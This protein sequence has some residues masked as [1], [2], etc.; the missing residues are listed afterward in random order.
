MSHPLSQTLLLQSAALCF[1]AAF[2]SASSAAAFFSPGFDRSKT[3][4][5]PCLYQTFAH[6]DASMIPPIG[7]STTRKARLWNCPQND[8]SD[9]TIESERMQLS[10]KKTWSDE[11]Q[12]NAV[13]LDLLP[14]ATSNSKNTPRKNSLVAVIFPFMVIAITVIFLPHLQ[15]L[16]TIIL[17][18][19]L[20]SV[21][22]PLIV[23][24]EFSEDFLTTI[25]PDATAEN[26]QD[27]RLDS[28]ESDNETC[29]DDSIVLLPLQIDATLIVLSYL[30]SSL[31]L[32]PDSNNN[33]LDWLDDNLWPVVAL[34]GVGGAGWVIFQQ[35]VVDP[36]VSE[37]QL[38]YQDKLM[39]TWDRAFRKEQERE[40]GD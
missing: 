20:R 9:D 3:I 2:P 27:F 22:F 25:S 21:A 5:V 31:L 39:N 16:L 8:K 28:D 17:F 7:R 13:V 1:V 32:P 18:V 14:G 38:S 35:S 37:E 30:S 12:K 10:R 33:S 19:A 34:L 40:S 23:C 15:A 6:H 11:D 26:S 36:V 4:G 24:E 29:E